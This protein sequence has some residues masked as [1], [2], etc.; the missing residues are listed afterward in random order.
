MVEIVNDRPAYKKTLAT[1]VLLI[2]DFSETHHASRMSM[3]KV[4]IRRD[5]N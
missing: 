1:N 4:T 5:M 2:F 3:M